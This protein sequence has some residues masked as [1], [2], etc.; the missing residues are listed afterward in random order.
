MRD[1]QVA[2]GDHSLDVQRQVRILP[3][4]PV[5]EAGERLGPVLGL[6]VVL[7][8]AGA[9]VILDLATDADAADPKQLAET[10]VL[11]L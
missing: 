8:I 6:G 1:H 11:L 4:Q 10:L 7:D 9:E 3:A 2:L 5:D